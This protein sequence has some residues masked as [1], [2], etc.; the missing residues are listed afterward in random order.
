MAVNACSFCQPIHL[1]SSLSLDV[2][3]YVILFCIYSNLLLTVPAILP[4]TITHTTPASSNIIIF[5]QFMPAYNHITSPT[6][7][8]T[9]ILPKSGINKNII[10]KT[11]LI[12]TNDISI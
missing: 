5:F 9:S 1:L 12:V 6:S 3:K 2:I 7:H 11:I 8:I 10:K 4:T